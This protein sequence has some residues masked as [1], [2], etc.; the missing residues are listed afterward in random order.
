[1]SKLARYMQVD[2]ANKYRYNP[3]RDAIEAGIVKCA[4]LS[5]DY[6]EAI[7]FCN[8]QNELLDE[9]RKE[10]KYLKNLS[11][12][13]IV[14]DLVRSYLHSLEYSKLSVKSKHDYAYYIKQWSTSRTAGT[15]LHH[16]R[17]SALSAPT[18][19]RIYDLHATHSV[20]LA[21]HVLAVYR[22]L[23]SYAIRNGF[24]TF[25]PFTNVKRRSDKPRR[26]VWSRDDVKAFVSLALSK[27]EWRSIGLIVYTAY[28]TAQRLGDMRMLTWDNYDVDTGVL[29][30]E[31]S[32]RR[33]RVS[34]P[35]S[36]SL[37]TM[38]RQQHSETSWQKYMFPTTKT[39]GDGHLKPYTLHGLANLGRELM[40]KANLPAELQMMDLRRTAITE[41]VE[42]AV[43]ISNIM[44]MSGHATP[45]SL[46][47]YMKATLKSSTV[48]QEMRGL[49]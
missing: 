33:A 9:W 12:K 41:M 8:N 16:T 45:H 27:Y 13:S 26:V 29:T 6:A 30:L 21:N 24:T 2:A 23:F 48:A 10:H 15:T 18:C 20:S 37:Q 44:S 1:M 4:S 42:A 47:P 25:N 32:K 11:E 46:T 34:I 39:G 28:V 49:V 19:Q 22:L 36:Q 7:T 5:S 31:Q 38:L 17:L 43:P 40:D 3:P 14:H 35:V